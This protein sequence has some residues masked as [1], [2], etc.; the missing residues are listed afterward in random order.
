[1][2]VILVY[3]QRKRQTCVLPH[4][5]QLI[6]LNLDL[7][8]DVDYFHLEEG[9]KDL[10]IIYIKLKCLSSYIRGQAKKKKLYSVSCGSLSVN[11]KECNVKG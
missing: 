4:M 3:C 8:K 1:M 9:R 7:K 5:N 6:S 10:N 11:L 2:V